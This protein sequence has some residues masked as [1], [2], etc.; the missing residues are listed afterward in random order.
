MNSFLIIVL[1]AIHGFLVLCWLPFAIWQGQQ[2]SI[3]SYQT[4][5]FLGG[6]VFLLVLAGIMLQIVDFAIYRL[7]NIR[8]V[9]IR[10]ISLIALVMHLAFCA[11][12]F[13]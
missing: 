7:D 3:E 5:R 9:S 12:V 4:L 6:Q 13:M 10:L 1:L 11:S 2:D 8:N